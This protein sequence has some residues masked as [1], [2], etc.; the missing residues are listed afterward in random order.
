[1][2]R[3]DIMLYLIYCGLPDKTAFKIMEDVGAK[4]LKKSTRK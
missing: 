1:M 3:D 4:G 2:Y